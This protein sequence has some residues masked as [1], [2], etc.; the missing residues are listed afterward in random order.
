MMT[1]IMIVTNIYYLRKSSKDFS[2]S[3]FVCWH[4]VK[5]TQLR[6]ERRIKCKT[7]E[8]SETEIVSCNFS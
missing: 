8:K 6:L 1:I 7:E 5:L 4:G 2:I 3:I